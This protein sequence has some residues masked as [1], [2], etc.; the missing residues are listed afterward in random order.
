[1]TG[2]ALFALSQRNTA[3]DAR[4]TSE[5]NAVVAQDNEAQVYSLFLA[6][7]AQLLN[8]T[9]PELAL[10]LALEANHTVS[11]P[12][13]AQRILA[14]T[15]YAPGVRRAFDIGDLSFVLSPITGTNTA[16]KPSPDGTTALVTYGDFGLLTSPDTNAVGVILWDLVH[17]RELEQWPGVF[18]GFWLSDGQKILLL[19]KTQ[20]LLWNVSDDILEANLPPVFYD[21]AYAP[22]QHSHFV[23]PDG[24]TL[25]RINDWVEIIIRDLESGHERS[26]LR[27]S[28]DPINALTISSDWSK[29]AVSRSGYYGLSGPNSLEKTALVVADPSTGAELWEAPLNASIVDRLAFSPDNKT[30]L[31]INGITLSLYDSATGAVIRQFYSNEFVNLNHVLFSADGRTV[32]ADRADAVILWDISTGTEVRQLDWPGANI[33][34]I[35]LSQD[36]HRLYAI[37]PEDTVLHVM[38]WDVAPAS[39]NPTPRGAHRSRNRRGAEH[40]RRNRCLCWE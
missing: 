40:R 6:T 29:I 27:V 28:T 32:Y 23:S 35:A 13:L 3:D 1:M 38:E 10:A 36:R 16:L 37:W 17:D 39:R 25:I 11:P 14:E 24:K 8:Y 31:S 19:G 4:A 12:P 21:P 26:I 34:D 33:K 9:D 2:L 22:E 7:N 20:T 18:T 5:A 15:A 30:L